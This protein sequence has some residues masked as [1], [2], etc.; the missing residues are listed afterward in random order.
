M[1]TKKE[2]K[3]RGKTVKRK[4]RDEAEVFLRGYCN[5]ITQE[6]YRKWLTA[7]IDY[8]RTV[9]N[10]KTKEE[11]ATHIQEYE[12]Y[13]ESQ[14]FTSSTIHNYLAPV[15]KYYGVSMK[16]IKKPIRHPSE[17][18]KSRSDN[19]K[20]I[21]A[22]NNPDNPRYS[23]TVEFQ[24]R[25]GIRVSE[26][27]KLEGRDLK[28]DESGYYCVFVK[29]GKGGKNQ[30]QRILPEDIDF[31][32]SYFAGK[33][34]RE[35]L[36]EKDE[37]SNSIDYHHIRAR[38]AKR[39]YEY[40]LQQITDN[41][42]NIVKLENEIRKRWNKECKIKLP[43]GTTAIKPFNEKL[44][45]GT[46]KVRGKNKKAA[47]KYGLPTEYNQLAL[48]AVSLFHLSHWRNDVTVQSYLL[49]H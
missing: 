38:Q 16:K 15:C 30:M 36:F 49:S 42:S 14:N 17:Y 39:A 18:T 4:L 43:D 37:F 19:G 35:K 11:C 5:K 41:P 9:H 20:K 46:Y 47:I 33:G 22:D 31:V 34:E 45:H 40:Y 3:V 23:R 27:K 44:L 24:K 13:L 28:I 48:T 6:N 2:N 1:I 12:K 8:C 7:Y 26:L 21:R 29:S 10:C 25:V 32:K